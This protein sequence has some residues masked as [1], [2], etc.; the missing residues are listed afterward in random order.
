[1]SRPRRLGEGQGEEATPGRH[2][3][4]FHVI[5]LY[6]CESGLARRD[7]PLGTNEG[8]AFPAQGA[9]Q[10][11]V[12][13]G[14]GR[15]VA[16]GAAWVVRPLPVYESMSAQ[17]TLPPV[18]CAD[19]GEGAIDHQ[20]PPREHHHAG[21]AAL[22]RRWRRAFPP[23]AVSSAHLCSLSSVCPQTDHSAWQVAGTQETF[24]K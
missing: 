19:R 18:H 24:S 23:L 11:W 14:E 8:A 22:S 3:G 10:G 1:M 7:F 13:V 6:G 4:I 17:Q 16:L 15:P 20:W 5:S 2:K 9:G 21:R 12:C